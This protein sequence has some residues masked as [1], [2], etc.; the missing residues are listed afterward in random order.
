MWVRKYVVV[1]LRY[2]V[3]KELCLVKRFLKDVEWPVVQGWY[4][5]QKISVTE[6]WKWGIY[7]E[8]YCGP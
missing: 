3:S 7:G 8:L 4:K 5:G 1:F 2:R 6:S